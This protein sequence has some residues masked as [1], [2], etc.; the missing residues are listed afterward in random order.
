MSKLKIS[1]DLSLP[2]SAQTQTLVVYGGKGMGKTNFGSVLVEELA[3][4]G[5]RFSV[6]DALDVWWGLQHGATKGASGLDVVILGGPHGDIPIEPGAGAVV[7]DF[8]ADEAASTVI[9]LRKVNG[10]MWT[11]GERIRFVTDYATRLFARQGERR[12]PLMQV[13]DEAGRFCPQTAGKGDIEIAKCIG[14]I[15]Q[16]VEWG[17]NVGVGVCLLTQRSARMA[18]AVSELADCMV[19]FRTVGPNS[20]EAIVDWF[21]EHVP[22]ERQKVLIER[23][24][25]LERGTALV[26]SPGWLGFEGAARMRA[27][28]TFDSSSTPQAGKSLRAPGQ[29]T[30]P[31]LEKYRSRM[32]ATIERAKAE[33]PKELRRQLAEAQREL[34]AA[35]RGS[36]DPAALDR[37][38]SEGRAEVADGVAREARQL[39]ARVVASAEAGRERASR[40]LDQALEHIKRAADALREPIDVPE[41]ALPAIQRHPIAARAP[42]QRRETPARATASATDSTLDG[43][44]QRIL[45]TLAWLDSI[46]VSDPEECAVAFLAGYT[47][48]GGAWNNPRGRLSTAGLIERGDGRMRLTDAGRPLSRVP[49]HPLTVEELHAAVFAR[50]PGPE[51]KILRV[52]I[53]SYPELVEN[54]ELAERSGYTEGGGAFN[55]PRGRLRSLGLIDYAKGRSRARPLLF[56][57]EK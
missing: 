56:L 46:G 35:K 7:A 52:L 47:I 11:N 53:D 25:S 30:K 19:A 51:S 55:N 22:K 33:D 8:V 29:A 57:E 12:I 10:E 37:A 41:V 50:L 40:A 39:V 36:I 34:A 48:G 44:M 54:A 27:R 15:E 2:A 21:G 5:L 28:E 24:R 45:D 26:V 43:P 23:L 13:I 42:V 4:Q 1:N 38:R 3:K 49:N 14:A 17:R 18:K 32:A 31:D 16:L 6:I 9:V 20:I